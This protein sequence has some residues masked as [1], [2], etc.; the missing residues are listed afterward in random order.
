[1]LHSNHGQLPATDFI[2]SF[3]GSDIY[4]YP[5]RGETYFYVRF[6]NR[7]SAYSDGLGSL[8]DAREVARFH[9][10]LDEEYWH[11][12]HRLIG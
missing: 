11:P 12:N 2:E 10:R 6:D 5:V 7:E 4:G 1:M 3:E 8:A 9:A